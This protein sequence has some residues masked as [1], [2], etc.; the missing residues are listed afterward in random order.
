MLTL[1]QLLC[2]S[3]RP[4]CR[5]AATTPLTNDGLCCVRS[6]RYGAGGFDSPYEYDA[7]NKQA[8]W[9]AERHARGVG[10]TGQYVFNAGSCPE[11]GRAR[12]LD[13]EDPM[14]AN[15]TRFIN[16]SA[17]RPNLAV[18]YGRA[19]GGDSGGSDD[20]R[21][22]TSSTE[23]SPPSTASADAMPIVR[24]VVS[25]RIDEGEEMLFD[26]GEGFELDVLDFED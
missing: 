9:V 12:L 14:H 23:G 19:D 3:E 22:G 25:Q 26:Y 24:F 11:T 21:G 7:A 13:A 8:A 16:H 6:E 17:R 4:T 15:W 18:E 20:A 2:A 1:G 5:P 10:V